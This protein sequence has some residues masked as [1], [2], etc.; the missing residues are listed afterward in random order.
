MYVKYHVYI[1]FWC[2]LTLRHTKRS[3]GAQWLENRKRGHS[4]KQ[5]LMRRVSIAKPRMRSGFAHL[6]HVC[7]WEGCWRKA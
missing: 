7:E 4:L 1:L 2:V 6:E 3:G 5:T